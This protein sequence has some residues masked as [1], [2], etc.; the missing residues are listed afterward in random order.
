MSALL[1]TWIKM[2]GVVK[3]RGNLCHLLR[4]PLSR[5]KPHFFCPWTVGTGE[6]VAPAARNVERERLG[7]ES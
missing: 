3:R 6:A 2:S 1:R 5:F 7:F 4:G